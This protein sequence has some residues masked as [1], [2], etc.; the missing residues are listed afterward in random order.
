M[1][2]HTLR[3][4]KTRPAQSARFREALPRKELI[5]IIYDTDAVQ[6]I[7]DREDM[8]WA[9][10]NF[11]DSV[12][13]VRKKYALVLVGRDDSNMIAQIHATRRHA[14]QAEWADDWHD[15]PAAIERLRA[16]RL[17]ETFPDEIDYVID[18]PYNRSRLRPQ[19]KEPAKAL[20]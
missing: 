8:Q 2:M 1:S 20:A 19:K 14:D 10:E 18:W 5:L 11:P 13:E 15:L 16:R 4:L 3:I 12:I 7:T 9:A 17:G 6:K